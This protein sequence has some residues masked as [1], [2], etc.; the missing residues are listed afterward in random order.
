MNDIDL[1]L[2]PL[3]VVV[4]TA[5]V[6][7]SSRSWWMLR[8]AKADLAAAVAFAPEDAA[9]IVIGKGHVRSEKKRLATQVA[10]TVIALVTL[11]SVFVDITD[12]ARIAVRLAALVGILLVNANSVDMRRTRNEAKAQLNGNGHL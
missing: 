8:D 10:F 9:L 6:I 7:G 4:L 5:G 12:W 11:V 1:V 3:S 2:L